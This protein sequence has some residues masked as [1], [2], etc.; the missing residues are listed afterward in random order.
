[1]QHHKAPIQSDAIVMLKHIDTLLLSH[2]Q[3]T[4]INKSTG[5]FVRS[6]L[7]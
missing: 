4:T 6:R 1:V 3:S 7:D 2:T 5:N